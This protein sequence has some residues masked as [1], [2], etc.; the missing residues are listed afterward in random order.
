M[1]PQ[2]LRPHKKQKKEEKLR[3]LSSARML[4]EGS[5]KGLCQQGL[6]FDEFRRSQ[7]AL[8]FAT[9]ACFIANQGIPALQLD[10]KDHNTQWLKINQRESFH[11]LK[12]KKV[13]TMLLMSFMVF[14]P[15]LAF[16]LLYATPHTEKMISFL[17]TLSLFFLT[18]KTQRKE[19]IHICL[20]FKDLALKVPRVLNRARF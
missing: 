18:E 3:L 8:Q 9:T 10:T 17:T 19:N 4:L 12:K 6:N 5:N 15:L 7:Q 11:P 14:I 13:A 1:T 16:F 20:C 2:V